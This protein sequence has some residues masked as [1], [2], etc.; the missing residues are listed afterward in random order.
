MKIT[1][2]E[3]VLHGPLSIEQS[4]FARR[5]QRY[6]SGQPLKLADISQL[7]WAAQGITSPNGYRTCPSAGALY[8]L[9][10]LIIAGN[11]EELAPG[12]YRYAPQ[13]HELVMTA[14]GDVRPALAEASLG[15]SSIREAPVSFLFTAIYERTTA[16]YGRRG[17]QYVHMEAG[18]AAQNICLQ[19]TALGLGTVMIGAFRDEEVKELLNL[20]PDEEPLYI[21]PA[22]R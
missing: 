5:C 1:L 16:K 21:L 2:P 12:V 7:A 6:Y 4:L 19:A 11:V 3:P 17:I 22:G 13:G 15:Q 8:P 20:A 9:A 10:L 18:H 14:P